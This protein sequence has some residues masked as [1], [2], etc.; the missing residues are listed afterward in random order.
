MQQLQLSACDN[1]TE[2]HTLPD[3]KSS[4]AMPNAEA[5]CIF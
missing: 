4:Q 3:F 5:A 1:M 2:E